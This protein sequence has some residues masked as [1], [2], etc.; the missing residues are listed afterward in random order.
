V[1]ERPDARADKNLEY[2]L[3]W[4]SLAATVIALWLLLNTRIGRPD[5]SGVPAEAVG[6][7]RTIDS[8]G[9]ES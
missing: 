4:Y 7:P 1:V 6:P 3:T 5:N 2:M 8:K 9:I